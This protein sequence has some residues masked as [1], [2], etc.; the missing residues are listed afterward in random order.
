MY[1]TA[2]KPFTFVIMPFH[3]DFDDLYNLGIK[4]ACDE[5]GSYCERVDEQI[6]AESIL[7]R[8]YN[9]IGKADIVNSD[10]TGRSPNVFYE[11][12]Y[13]HALGKTVILLASTA[14]D[15]PFDLQHYSHIVYEGRISYLKEELQ[16]RVRWYI[17]NPSD[18]S[19]RPLFQLE[20]Y[21]QG[22]KL[23]LDRPVEVAGDWRPIA[24]REKTELTSGREPGGWIRDTF[25]LDVQGLALNIS[26]S[27]PKLYL[28]KGD[29]HIGVVTS[30]LFKASHAKEK[31]VQ[32]PDGK[33]MYMLEGPHSVLPQG[34]ETATFLLEPT[35][36]KD[37]MDRSESLD[38]VV[39]VFTEFGP[40]DFPLRVRPPT[41]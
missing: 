22:E 41:P 29:F 6:F 26:M 9:Q 39:R 11:T 16:R 31:T 38:I 23:E 7:E 35:S 28:Y 4:P 24:T 18:G 3:P 1:D 20:L 33:V 2:P 25:D 12:G 19:R 30:S 13:A 37:V 34:W 8:I 21:V 36:M 15:I 5:A 14:D 32:L 10:V 40:Q 27:N 17:E